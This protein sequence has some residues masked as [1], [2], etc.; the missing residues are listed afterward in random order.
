VFVSLDI[1]LHFLAFDGV[2]VSENGEYIHCGNWNIPDEL[3]C[4]IKATL[5]MKYHHVLTGK[6]KSNKKGHYILNSCVTE[7][8]VEGGCVSIPDHDQF[9]KHAKKELLYKFP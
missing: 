4:E 8:R 2:A 5:L 3:L 7:T 9:I 1:L 6:V